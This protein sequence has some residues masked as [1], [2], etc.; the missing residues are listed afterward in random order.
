MKREDKNT[1][2]ENLKKQINESNH[3]YLAD[4]SE[5]NAS[6]TSSLRR[7]CFE[8]D[9]KLIVVKNTLLKR[10]LENSEGD[11]GD[12]YAVCKDSTS[13]MF[14]DTGNIPAKLIKEFRKEHHK[15]VL[16]AAYVEESIYVGDQYLDALTEIKSKEELLG[17]LILLLQ[18]PMRNILSALQSGSNVLTGV[19][20]TL[21]DKKE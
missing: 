7:K 16:K 13:I 11:F 21:S 3:F 18:S 6:D 17:D 2:I 14:S 20:R 8:K 5:L 4:I 9:I 1:I 12:L 15:P 19:L 10:A